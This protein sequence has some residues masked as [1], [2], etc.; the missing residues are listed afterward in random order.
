L[1][2]QVR[3]IDEVLDGDDI[4]AFFA[5][6]DLDADEAPELPEQPRQSLYPDDI[7]FLDEALRAGFN[8]VPHADP[9]AGGVAWT[10]H[11]DH[12]IAELVPPKDLRQRLIQLPQNYLQHGRV[13]ERLKLAT[14]TQV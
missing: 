8:D 11:R 13:L 6:M 14:S 3:S 4:D 9:A 2:D 5:Q 10:V 1:D 12:G 7:S